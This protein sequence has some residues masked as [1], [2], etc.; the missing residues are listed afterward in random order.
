[1]LMMMGRDLSLS[2][3][4]QAVSWLTSNAAAT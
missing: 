3:L 2:R 1:M 4:D